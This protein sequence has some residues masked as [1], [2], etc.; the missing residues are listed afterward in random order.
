MHGTEGGTDQ[1]R[2][3]SNEA[4]GDGRP[5]TEHTVPASV[6]SASEQEGGSKGESD[7]HTLSPPRA[8]FALKVG[9]GNR[10]RASGARHGQCDHI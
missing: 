8:L 1:S 2:G 6:P 5:V 10:N 3:Y 9:T 4:S 7:S